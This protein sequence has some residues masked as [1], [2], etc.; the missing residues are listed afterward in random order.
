MLNGIREK[1]INQIS[2]EKPSSP[3]FYEHEIFN[4]VCFMNNLSPGDPNLA[5]DGNTNRP[6]YPEKVEQWADQA[7]WNAG[8]AIFEFLR[9]ASSSGNWLPGNDQCEVVWPKSITP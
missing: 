7:A 2:P 1:C 3:V 6:L 4:K 8:W 9:T 5:Y